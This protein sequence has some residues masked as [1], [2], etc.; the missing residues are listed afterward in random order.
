LLLAS[1]AALL[2]QNK[3]DFAEYGRCFLKVLGES[4]PPALAELLDRD[5]ARLL[6]ADFDVEVPKCML[7]KPAEVARVCAIANALLDLQDRIADLTNADANALKVQ[8]ADLAALRKWIVAWGGKPGVAEAPAIAP[9][10]QPCVLVFAPDRRSFVGIVGWLG[11][12]KE[13]YRDYWWNDGTAQWT[14]VGVHD[15]GNVQIVALEYPSPTANGDVTAGFD[16]NTRERT[17]MLQHVLQRAGMSWCWRTL[18]DDADP[19]FAAGFA[20]ALVVDV[21]GQNNARS[22]GSGKSSTTEGRGAFIPGAP[23]RGGGMEMVNADSIWRLSQGSDWFARPLR[24][25]QKAGEHE[26]KASKDKFGH[27]LL[28][29]AK[30]EHTHLVDG[31]FLGGAAFEREEV[32]AAYVD[33]YLEFHRAYRAGFVHWLEGNGKKGKTQSLDAFRDLLA[34][35]MAKKEGVT[36]EA[37]YKEVY[38]V[39]LSAKTADVDTL[40]RRFLAWVAANTK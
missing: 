2:A 28:R 30:G 40:E 31:P 27:F 23:S 25:A 7:A 16:M 13:Q 37:L 21:L 6:L 26:A 32:P 35:L 36:L 12:W 4:Q 3:V 24:Q 8:H 17:G 14:D 29:D 34:L 1:S 5:Y 20:T 22:G 10:P 15:E 19:V 39:P 9:R 38:G 18:G 11:L 33:D